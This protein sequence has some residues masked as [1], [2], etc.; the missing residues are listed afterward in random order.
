MWPT[1]RLCDL[2]G[3][4]LPIVQAPM[5]G[6]TRPDLATAV[7]NA[8]GPSSL[9]LGERSP[10]GVAE[11]VQAMRAATYRP[12]NI[13]FFA[14][15]APVRGTAA[16]ARTR[17]ASRPM[18]SAS[19]SANRPPPCRRRARASPRR[20]SRCCPRARRPRSDCVAACPAADLAAC[21]EREARA[22]FARPGTGE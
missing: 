5:A 12:F 2:P 7:S 16:L 11:A 9:G 18:T 15:H 1:P 10:E 20:C 8:G 19:G 21:L 22:A 4:L 3:F 17:E 6:S 14:C 13:N